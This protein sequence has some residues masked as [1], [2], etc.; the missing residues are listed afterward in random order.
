MTTTEVQ[1]Q[2]RRRHAAIATLQASAPPLALTRGDWMRSLLVFVAAVLAL[3]LADVALLWLHPGEYYVPVG[4]YRDKLF[5]QR[6]NYQE[7]ASDGTTYR[8]TTADS[9]LWL[10]QIG[11]ARHAWLRL[12]LGGRP[13][14]DDVRLT[15]NGA[16]WADFSATTQ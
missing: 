3:L 13:Q 5:L 8:W 11:V 12:D 10:N 15:L 1:A 9:T 2:Q 6:V 4:N 14:A 16:P 7:T